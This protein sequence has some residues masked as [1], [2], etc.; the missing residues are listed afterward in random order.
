MK[1]MIEAGTPGE[2]QKNIEQLAGHWGA[3]IKHR[4]DPNGPWEESHGTEDGKMMYEG[5]YLHSTFKSNM[6]GMPFE[7]TSVFAYDNTARAYQSTWVDSMSTGIFYLSGTYDAAKKSWSL[8]GDMADP[9]Q[10]GKK[11]TTR[12]VITIHSPDK[13]TS[14]FF[15]PGPDGKEMKVMEITYTRGGSESHADKP[16]EKPAK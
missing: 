5:R 9:M 15:E 4:M 16:A 7:G 12:M 13:H 10:G 11:K 3:V 1:A 6:E 8:K 14:E 2:G